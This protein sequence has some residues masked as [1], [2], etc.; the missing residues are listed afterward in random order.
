MPELPEVETTRRGIAPV[1]EGRRVTAVTVRQSR[2]RWPVPV[3]RLRRELVGQ[4]VAAVE[5]RAKYL[6]L[7][8]AAGTAL[9]HLGMSG[10]L[11]VIPADTPAGFHDHLD[12]VLDDGACLRLRD[13]RRFGA[14]LWTRRDPFLHPLLRELGP[15]PFDPAFDG[16]YLRAR[17]ERRRIAV[18]PFLMDGHVVVGVGNIYASESLH[19]AGIDPRRAAGRVALAL[20][21][22]AGSASTSPSTAVT[23]SRACRVARPCVARC[24]GSA[25]PF[26]APAASTEQ[27]GRNEKPGCWPGFIERRVERA[28]LILASL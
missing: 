10:S 22:T 8:T 12:L 13:P 9:L 24:S 11:R 28:Y 20:A 17:A 6:L 16:A 15:E 21:R 26:S 3:G 7:R 23:A 1:L 2:L 25:R 4:R 27:H 19:R 18:K 5:R 14:L